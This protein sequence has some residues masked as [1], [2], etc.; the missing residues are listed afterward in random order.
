MKGTLYR[1]VRPATWLVFQIAVR[2]R[3]RGQERVPHSYGQPQARWFTYWSAP[4]LRDDVESAGFVEID[5]WRTGR[6]LWT[7]LCPT[8]TPCWVRS[9]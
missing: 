7:T 1:V 6:W 2:Q 3:I 5:I 8:S 4:Q 9:I